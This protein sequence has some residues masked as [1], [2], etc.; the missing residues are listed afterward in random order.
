[1]AKTPKSKAWD[2]CSKYIRLRDA[3]EY[4]KKYKIDLPPEEMVVKCCTCGKVRT[5]KYM[6]AGHYKSRGSGGSS[7][8]YFDERGIN[9]QCGQCNAFK[10]GAPKEY[11]EFMLEK[12]GEEVIE[13][14][15]RKHQI[16]LQGGVLFYKATEEMYKQKY[17]QL[18]KE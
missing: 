1:M 9:T 7:G 11:K 8:I 6:Q 13:E 16:P 4:C 12:Y 15:E 3:I 17:Q 18:L 2:A 5:W 14:L 10:Q